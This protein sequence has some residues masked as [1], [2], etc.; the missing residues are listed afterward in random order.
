MIKIKLSNAENG[1]IKTITDSQYNGADQSVEI[2]KVYE[3][4]EDEFYFDKISYLL[5]DI[6]KDL[7]FDLG[8]QFDREQ[9]S[10]SIDWGEKYLPSLEE[11]DEKI[12]D[13]KDEIKILQTY[14]KEILLNKP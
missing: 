12:K 8:N 2:T 7:G 10:F 1:V 9:L 14:K 6:S 13:L 5:L 4:N 11:V 3:I